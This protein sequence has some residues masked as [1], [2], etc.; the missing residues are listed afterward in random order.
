MTV[1]MESIV[2]FDVPLQVTECIV[3]CFTLRVLLI[4][5]TIFPT[6]PR[7]P[8]FIR[9]C[10]LYRIYFRLSLFLSLSYQHCNDEKF[11]SANF[12][13]FG[14]FCV[15]GAVP[16]VCRCAICGCRCAICVCRCAICVCRCAI[17]MCRCAM[18]L[19]R[20]AI[21]EKK[22]ILSFEPNSLN[23]YSRTMKYFSL[24][25]WLAVL[26]DVQTEI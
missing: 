22:G 5:G 15:C 1:V 9:I 8:W 12:D 6:F 25:W 17:C 3:Q 4:S 20:C 16:Y 21:S 26:P 13:V 2:K 10:F 24:I 11:Y 23:I 19:C 18:C 14:G 7:F